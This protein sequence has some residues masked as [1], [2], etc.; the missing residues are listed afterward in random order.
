MLCAI[1]SASLRA[2]TTMTIGGGTA[3]SGCRPSSRSRQSQNPPRANGAPAEFRLCELVLE[4]FGV[5]ACEA[6]LE[7][8]INAGDGEGDAAG[9]S[10]ARHF[11]GI[12]RQRA[13]ELVVVGAVEGAA[14]GGAPDQHQ[15]RGLAHAPRRAG[16]ASGRRVGARSRRDPRP[17]APGIRAAFRRGHR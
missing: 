12:G 4:V 7:R 16:T 6:F 5:D 17:D 10:S 14:V 8:A 13:D 9:L 2:G 1:F 11:E 15:V 3:G